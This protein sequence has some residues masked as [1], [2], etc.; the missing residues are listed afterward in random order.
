MTSPALAASARPAVDRSRELAYTSYLRVLAIVGVVFIHIAGLSFV[1]K[2]LHGT[3]AWWLGAVM[4]YSSR[5]AVIVFV[6]VS[7]ALLLRPPAVPDAGRF[8]RK[9]LAKLGIPLLVWHA[10]Y[11]TLQVVSWEHPPAP[12]RLLANLLEGR[13]YTALYFFWLILGLYAVTPLLWPLVQ[14]WSRCALAVAGA[15]LAALPALD[16]V[17]QGLIALLR[18]QPRVLSTPTLVTQFLP[19]VGFFLLGYALRDVAVRGARLVALVGGL[20]ALLAQMVLQATLSK[21]LTADG[22]GVV[23]ALLPLNYQGTVVGLSAVAVFVVVKSLVHPGSRLAR[24]SASR[25]ARALGELTFGVFACHLLVF[26]VLARLPGVG[27]QKGATTAPGVLAL[28]AAVV[29]VS[30]AFAW[31]LSRTPLLRRAV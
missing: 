17:L 14:A 18:E 6:M 22:E 19:Y 30:F 15:A 3:P 13:S 20:L 26:Y 24:P 21:P 4:N 9:R 1:N 5:W 7:G 29:V 2:D 12:R 8:Y 11:I 10:V 16:V 23:N 28:N 25:R 31:L 27:L